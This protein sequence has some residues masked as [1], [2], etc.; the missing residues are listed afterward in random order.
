[1]GRPVIASDLGALPETITAAGTAAEF[2]GWLVTPADPAALAG[3]IAHA[4][5]LSPAERAKI[6]ERGRAR[7]AARFT[8]GRLQQATL[9]VYDE[10]LGS[11]LAR[12]FNQGVP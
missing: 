3:A 9:A 6:G 1:M 7:A 2:T 11:Q 5:A 10:L 12:R 4:F 8:L